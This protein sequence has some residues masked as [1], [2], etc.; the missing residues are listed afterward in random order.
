MYVGA[1]SLLW[2]TKNPKKFTDCMTAEIRLDQ[3][4]ENIKTAKV[5]IWTLNFKIHAIVSI[6]KLLF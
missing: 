5:T 4:T 3:K 2:F 6:F 1:T